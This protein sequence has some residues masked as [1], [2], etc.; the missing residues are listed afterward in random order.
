MKR[1]FKRTASFQVTRAWLHHYALVDTLTRQ[2]ANLKT[3][4]REAE[5]RRDAATE[6]SA[7]AEAEAAAAEESASERLR[8]ASRAAVR[9]EGGFVITQRADK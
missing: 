9:K 7:A 5:E 3:L 8:S 6:K 2:V 1:G 4:A